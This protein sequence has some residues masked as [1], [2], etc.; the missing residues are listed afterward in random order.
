MRALAQFAM[1]GRRQAI[2]AAVL[3]G[4]LPVVN[5][6]SPPVVA[7]VALR[8][9]KSEAMIVLAWA[10]L[11]ALGW[12]I[13]GD[14]IPL[15]L[16][17][18]ITVLA[19]VL[20]STGSW[21][22]TLLS[23]IGVG[24][25]A[26]MGLFLQPEFLTVMAEQITQ[27]ME[28]M[29]ASP[30]LQGQVVVT[31]PEQL[32]QWL[33]IVFGTMV[34]FFSVTLLMLAR[35]WQAGLYNPGGFRVEFHQLRLGWKASAILFSM[36]LLADIGAP[37]LQQLALFFLMPL[38]IAGVALVHGLVG[39]RKL[40]VAVL[41]IFYS[42]LISPVMFQLLALAALADSWFDFRSKVRQRE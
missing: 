25:G 1:S 10:V 4:F 33:L 20:R 35:S 23:S 31:E 14:M 11:P 21:E 24:I 39:R 13:L 41:V 27:L 5:F 7:L 28:Q 34:V 17:L 38:L 3:L 22:A 40:P 18:G 2:L 15:L 12:A 8:H 42:A 37:V 32:Q 9:G 19:L 26:Q 29:A 16:L 6:L 30:E 36:Y